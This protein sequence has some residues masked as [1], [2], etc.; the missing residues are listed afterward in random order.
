MKV[1]ISENVAAQLVGLGLVGLIVLGGWGV[2]LLVEFF[3]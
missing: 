3:A 2:L 1:T